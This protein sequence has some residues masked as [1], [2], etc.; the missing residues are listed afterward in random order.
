MRNNIYELNSNVMQIIKIYRD[1][2]VESVWEIFDQQSGQASIS[3]D[4]LA[5]KFNKICIGQ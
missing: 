4:F 1:I 2:P 5:W 3:S